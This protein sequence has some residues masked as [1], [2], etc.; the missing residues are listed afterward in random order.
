MKNNDKNIKSR[1][2]G[3]IISAIALIFSL[4]YL[5]YSMISVDK[6]ITSIDKLVVPLF[7]FI[8]SI[9]LFLAASKNNLGKTSAIIISSVLIVFMAFELLNNLNIIKLPQEEKIMSYTNESY[10]TLNE[11]AEKKGITLVTTYEYDDNIDKGNVISI[12]IK[13]GTPIKDVKVINVVISDGPDY[14]KIVVVPS[15]V[16]WNV[17]DVSKFVKDNHMIGV[18]IQYQISSNLKDSVITQ[19]SNGD[20]R[21]SQELILTLSLGTEAEVPTEV[22][23]I[24]L[25][26]KNIFDATLWLKRNNIKYTVEYKFSNSIDKNIVTDQNKD[27]DENINI[28]NDSI[29]ITVSKGKAIIVPDLV[30]M[31][32]EDITNWIV[33]NKLKVTFNEIYDTTVEVGKVISTSVTK[34]QEIEMN[35]LITVTVSKGQI[36]M[37]SFASLSEFKTWA[38]QYKISYNESYE[39]SNTIAKGSVISYSYNL[40]DV[41][42]PDAVIYIKVSLGKAITLPSFIGKSKTDATSTCNSLGIRCSFVTGTYTSY[43]TNVVYSQSKGQGVKVAAGAAITLTISKGLPTTKTLYIQ[44]NWLSIGNA[45]STISSLRTQF[46]NNYPGVNFTFIKVKDNTYSSGMISKSSPTNINSSVTQGQTYTIYIV[47]N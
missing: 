25:V 46:A 12:D 23:M 6:L 18:V 39:Y 36:K 34:G 47:S 28:T 22:K 45:D 7:I 3:A 40:N 27:K 13:E 1:N 11:W 38:N 21:R 44:Q 43:A 14:D 37:Q 26:N 24:D 41:I 9:L 2:V 5:T 4:A 29:I 16:G 42:D 20:I 10:A 15:M 32:V 33:S 8:L 17:D 19:S 30:S 31:S 35:T